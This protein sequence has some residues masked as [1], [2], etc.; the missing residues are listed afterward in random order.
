MASIIFFFIVDF[1]TK[2]FDD[3]DFSGGDMVAA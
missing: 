2:L 1:L 3:D